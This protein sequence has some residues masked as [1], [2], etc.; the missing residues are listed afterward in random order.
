M[1]DKITVRKIETIGGNSVI[2]TVT[3]SSQNGWIER[4]V[5]FIAARTGYKVKSTNFQRFS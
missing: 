2:D 4:R 1:V 3:D 5:S